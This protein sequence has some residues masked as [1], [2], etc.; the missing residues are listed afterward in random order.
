[1]PA[2]L[3]C[4]Q[5]EATFSRSAH[6]RRHQKTHRAEK[7]FVCQFC[8]VVSSRRDVIVR[9]T[10]NFHPDAVPNARRQTRT[11]AKTDDTHRPSAASSLSSE[12]S[13]GSVP[14]RQPMHQ[15]Q[16]HTLRQSYSPERSPARSQAELRTTDV[17]EQLTI[18]LSQSETAV[19]DQIEGPPQEVSL[20]I[21]PEQC[22]LLVQDQAADP[23]RSQ[24]DGLE[25][26]QEQPEKLP[27]IPYEML[28][29]SLDYAFDFDLLE[30]PATNYTESAL[31]P[32]ADFPA[33]S[34]SDMSNHLAP[35]PGINSQIPLD[36]LYLEAQNCSPPIANSAQTSCPS[37]AD[38]SEDASYAGALANLGIYDLD[39]AKTT[40]SF[41]SKRVVYRFV[42]AYFRHMAPHMPLLHQPTFTIASTPSPL[43]IE[44]MAC[45]ALYL[46]ER[47]T[48][49]ELHAVARRF[50][51]NL[52][53][54]NDV[55]E[56]D[57]KFEVWTLQTYLLM[58]HFGAYVGTFAMHERATSMFPQT[59]KLA[60]DA[61]Q[62][63]N[64]CQ[65]LSYMDWVY[66][67]TLIRCIVHTIELGAALASTTKE[68]CFT[69]PFFDTPFPLP[70]SN[71]IWQ[72]TEKEW[73]GFFQQPDSGHVQD[74]IFAGQNPAS[75]ISD[76][77]LVTLISLILWRT[78][79]FEAFAGSY[80]L[81]LSADLV[82]RTGRAVRVLDTLFEE[83]VKRDEA[84]QTNPLL[85][86]A[87]ALLNSVFYHLYASETLTGMKRLLDYP[88]KR[89]LSDTSARMIDLE[90]SSHLSIALCRAA[91]SLQYDCQ[92][93]IH[94]VQ[95]MAPHRFGPVISTACY[96]GGLLL[97]WYLKN[98][99]TLFSNPEITAKLDQVIHELSTELTT[100]RETSNDRLLDL[101]LMVVAELLSDR[102]VWQFPSDVSEKLKVLTQFS[103]GVS[104]HT[105]LPA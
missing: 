14:A 7:P 61:L 62:E 31:A 46:C 65:T 57:G 48:A 30:F 42:D 2:L 37:A 104:F 105:M 23:D 58:S 88:R 53:R 12:R 102:S 18:A 5:C 21:E 13:V 101:P 76:L 39:H 95:R 63:L 19:L 40:F 97:S 32:L 82:N 67:E 29:A 91:E 6:L 69:A 59:I 99:S 52:E 41:P 60:Q 77:G 1:M 51:C 96:E 74:C 75:P 10:R 16:G 55:Q 43:L 85:R 27:S 35:S 70:S 93:G 49:V 83:R 15:S 44:I 71:T 68:Q 47:T 80:R 4:S 34:P 103:H 64:S 79:S 33:L 66:Q 8:P 36:A 54:Q 25:C 26:H 3:S 56:S 38:H 98:R 89:K 94:Y 72:Q 28:Q 50:M 90:H 17:H 81:D 84:S 9:H 45:G 78:C 20:H 11:A 92:M 87:R 86:I 100:L 24:H 22:E 73:Q